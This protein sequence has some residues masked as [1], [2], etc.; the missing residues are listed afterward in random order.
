MGSVVFAVALQ[1]LKH[2]PS[3]QVKE[4]DKDEVIDLDDLSFTEV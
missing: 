2:K 4:A 1:F 3:E